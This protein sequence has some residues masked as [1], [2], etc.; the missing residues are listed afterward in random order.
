MWP[1]GSKP[2]ASMPSAP[3]PTSSRKPSRATSHAGPQSRSQPISRS[4]SRR[5][6]TA[7]TSCLRVILL[8]AVSSI[9]RIMPSSVSLDAGVVDHLAP[10]FLLLTE[11]AIEGGRRVRHQ[12]EALIH[13]QLLEGVRLYRI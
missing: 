6:R 4:S 5:F 7:G 8:E 12:H 10:A 2:S 9:I 3:Q 11:I 1:R 13:A